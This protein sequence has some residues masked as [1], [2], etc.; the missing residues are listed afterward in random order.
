MP[1]N[2]II[3]LSATEA[4]ARFRD[5]SLSPVEL[6]EALIAR[7][8]ALDPSINAFSFRYFDEAMEAA[9]RAEA[10]YMKG[11]PRRLEGVP[12]A[13]KDEQYIRGQV[14]TNASLLLRDKVATH[15]S[16]IVERLL[17]AGAVVHARTTTPEFS[18]ISLT[19]SRLWGVSRNP[20]NLEYTPGGSSGGTAASLAAGTT[21][22]ATGSDIAGSIRIP[23]SACG[24]VGFKPPYGRNPEDPPFNLDT[25]NHPGGLA[26][27]VADSALMQNVMS[28]P[29]PNDIA[30]L[31]MRV[32]V[33][34]E[35]ADLRGWRIAF[36]PD[37][38]IF[39]V[40]P[41][42]DRNT[43]AMVDALRDLG[44]EV[45]EVDLGWP[46]EIARANW[47]HL[48]H[49]FGASLAVYLDDEEKAAQL[50]DYTRDFAER[51]RR[52]QPADYLH[53]MEVASEMYS[54]LGKVLQD[55]R[56][57]VCP[58][59]ALPAVPAALDT[60]RDEVRI[61]GVGVEP[62]LGWC[63]TWPFNMLSRCPVLSIPSGRAANGVPTGLQI[64]G[65]TYDDR[66]VYGIGAALEQ[67]RPWKEVHPGQAVAKGGR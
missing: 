46:P 53:S 26:R 1:D 25:Y 61:N 28:G 36:S 18:C 21:T 11:N 10:R 32:T 55:C 9:K 13:V 3:W 14:T 16:P 7:D 29:H 31:S 50:C 63:M 60:V 20:W 67:A 43:L 47:D 15:T 49:I 35:P 23:A 8:E 33:N 37:L 51:A 38:G 4:L 6:L 48:Y 34:P 30:T 12:L 5:R 22:L 54:S 39:E 19:H 52:S 64:V 62:V 66:T 17:R 42:V 58:T 40:D 27:T 45:E 24:V 59:L 41:E 57:L 44:A 56:A 2:E 65:R